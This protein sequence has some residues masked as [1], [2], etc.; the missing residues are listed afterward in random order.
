MPSTPQ[1]DEGGS[2]LARTIAQLSSASSARPRAVD[3]PKIPGALRLYRVTAYITGI[4]LLLLVAEMIVKYGMGYSLYAF[5]GYGP[6]AFVPYDPTGR[7]T[8]PSGVDLSTGIL[9]AHGWL[10]VLYLFADFRLWS[11]MRM[12]FTKFVQIALGGVIP[13]MS[14]IVEH[15]IT[16]QVKSYL[17]SREATEQ[18]AGSNVHA[19]NNAEASH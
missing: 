8:P 10:Y 15:L 13:F 7:I 18:L 1:S 5:S 2:L 6:L 4:M 12:S 16:K 17:A 9:I 14:F 19:P 11:L 3:I